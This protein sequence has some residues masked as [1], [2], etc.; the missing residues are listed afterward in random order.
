M[1]IVSNIF[2]NIKKRLSERQI[3]PEKELLSKTRSKTRNSLIR[4]NDLLAFQFSNKNK[5]KKSKK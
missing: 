4:Y 3:Y 5:N 1:E 2:Q